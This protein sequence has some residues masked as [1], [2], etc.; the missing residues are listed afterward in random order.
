[1]I[2]D[3]LGSR[4]GANDNIVRFAPC[5][6]LDIGGVARLNNGLSFRLVGQ[7]M[8]NS[9]CFN[10]GN[11]RNSVAE[12]LNEFGFARPVVGRTVTGTIGYRF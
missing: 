6:E 2:Y 10:E 9:I 8:T 3:W 5:G 12:N 4:F 1:V 11:P 7:N